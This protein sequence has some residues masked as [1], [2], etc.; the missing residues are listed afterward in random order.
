L[1]PQKVRDY[2]R[3]APIKG[4][5]MIP[6]SPVCTSKATMSPGE[7]VARPGET[8]AIKEAAN[9]HVTTPSLPW[10]DR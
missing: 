5:W 1:K 10:P 4:P 6:Q 9:G 2:H 8:S 3:R 7:H